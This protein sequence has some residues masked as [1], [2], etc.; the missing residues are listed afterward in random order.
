M[1][2]T[3]VRSIFITKRYD[4]IIKESLKEV[5]QTITTKIIKIPAKKITMLDCNLQITDEREAD[6]VMMIHTSNDTRFV[7]HLELQSTNDSNMIHRMLRYFVYL[8]ETYKLDVRQVLIYFGGDKLSM[9]NQLE[10]SNISYHY[11]IID[12]K[13]IPCETF[14]KSDNPIEIILIILCDFSLQDERIV[15]KNII[16]RLKEKIF[17][18]TKYSKYIRQLEILSQLR[19]LQSIV[20]EEE[21]K[22]AFI[23]DIEKDLRFKQGLN[24]GLE[25]GLEQ[26]Q[27]RGKLIGQILLIQQMKKIKLHNEKDLEMLSIDELTKLLTELSKED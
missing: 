25:Q 11:E 14:L 26:G 2:N 8:R 23:Y 24:R 12:M 17:E 16:Q 4:K 3:L 21:N 5:A 1:S 22:M 9:V 6:F 15:I 20:I 18:E 19:D 10:L 7:L 27:Q 13:D